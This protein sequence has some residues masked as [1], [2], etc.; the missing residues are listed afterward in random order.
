MEDIKKI[1]IIGPES[2][3]K[4]TLCQQLANHYQTSWCPEYAREYLM[5]EGK[6]YTYDDL[7]KIAEGQVECEENNLLAAQNGLYFIDTNQYVMKVWCEVAFD[8]CHPWILKQ[9]SS[10]KYD[11]YLL[12]NTDLTWIEDELREYPDFR[13][14]EKLFKMYKDL[15]VNDGTPWAVISGQQNERLEMAIKIVD[16]FKERVCR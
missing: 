1:V 2:T 13:F 7:L 9:I 15:L 10:R 5:R 14:R 16:D 12:C 4:S 3:G 6:H 8:Q 11:L